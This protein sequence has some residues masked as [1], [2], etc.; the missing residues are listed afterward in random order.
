MGLEVTK[1][2]EIILP[3]NKKDVNLDFQVIKVRIE[4]K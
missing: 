3:E 2:R 1:Y 4:S